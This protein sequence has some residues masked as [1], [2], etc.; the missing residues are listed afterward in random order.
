MVCGHV[1]HG[2]STVL[3]RLLADAGALPDGRLQQIVQARGPG[4]RVEYAFLI[5]AL[6]DERSRGITIDTARILLRTRRRDYVVLDAPG[7]AE[8][9]KNMVTGAAQA[10]TAIL[11]ID[12]SEGLLDNARRHARLVSLVGVHHV[13]VVVNK[14]DLAGLQEGRFSG[15]EA[16]TRALLESLDLNVLGVVPTVGCDGDN[17][18]DRST[19]L[20]WY[21]GPTLLELLEAC[22]AAEPDD[23]SPFRMPVQDV[24]QFSGRG[25]NRRIVAG[26]ITSGVLRAGDQIA[27]ARAGIEAVVTQFIGWNEAPRESAGAGEAVGFTL[28]TDVAVERGDLACAARGPFPITRSQI[29]VR[30]FWTGRT[31]L[32]ADREYLLKIGTAREAVRAGRFSRVVDIA[33]LEPA[34]EDRR[35]AKGQ[36]AE[37]TLET[38]RPVS[39]DAVSALPETGRFVI[40]DGHIISGGGIVLENTPDGGAG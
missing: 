17:V 27:F 4:T 16:E 31:P 25:D 32:S 24:Y 34:G 22:P 35:I 5:D 2:K 40:V 19:R 18:V 3:G 8:L 38:A 11:V 1:D 13:I 28:S 26:T 14:M 10:D 23:S 33:T 30:L 7:H 39:F 12:A 6:K 36:I 15:I 21:R 20:P 9:V 37:C 29:S